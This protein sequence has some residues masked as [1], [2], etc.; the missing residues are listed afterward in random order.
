MWGAYCLSPLAWISCFQASNPP[1][2]DSLSSQTQELP[3]RYLD[4]KLQRSRRLL[5]SLLFSVFRLNPSLLSE[6]QASSLPRCLARCVSSSCQVRFLP[7]CNVGFYLLRSSLHA[8]CQRFPQCDLWSLA[9]CGI[10][11]SYGEKGE[12]HGQMYSGKIKLQKVKQASFKK[13]VVK[14]TDHLP[15]YP[16]LS[17][18]FSGIR[19]IHI[20]V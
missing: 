8:T 3:P 2:E 13:I 12:F 17:V 10:Q 1:K 14:Y 4:I 20:V 18:D 7:Y 5:C 9:L 16:L 19:H 6:I 15:F 11:V